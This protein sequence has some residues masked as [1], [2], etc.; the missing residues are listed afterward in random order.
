MGL[1]RKSLITLAVVG[2]LLTPALERKASAGPGE[3]GWKE[4]PFLAERGGLK[5]AG[6]AGTASSEEE[7][8][9]QGILW[10]PGA[11]TAILSNRVVS[12]GDRL[13]VWQVMEIRK[14]RVI[15]SDGSSTREISAR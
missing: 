5:A 7:I 14:D 8:S 2:L 4:S 9:L 10:D 3:E 11:P 1:D 13:G 12:V 6:V 15:L